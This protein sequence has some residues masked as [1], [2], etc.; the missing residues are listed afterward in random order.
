MINK[1]VKKYKFFKKN[2][3]NFTNYF[4]NFLIFEKPTVTLTFLNFLTNSW[5]LV[6]CFINCVINSGP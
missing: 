5:F 4:N 2:K 3:Q 1:K 6:Q